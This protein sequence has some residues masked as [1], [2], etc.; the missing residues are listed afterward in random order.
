MKVILLFFFLISSLSMRLLG[1]ETIYNVLSNAERAQQIQ[2]FELPLTPIAWEENESLHNLFLYK[3]E[4]IKPIIEKIEI[5]T[6]PVD[7]K[8]PE[9]PS[10]LDIL[11]D[12]ARRERPKGSFF[13]EDHRVIALQGRIVGIGDTFKVSF[14]GETYVISILSLDSYSYTLGLNTER[15]LVPYASTLYKN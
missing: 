15:L 14:R 5:E 10:D 7:E 6:T 2:S 12:I 4:N 8:V 13:F 9:E 3:G 1:K 11:K